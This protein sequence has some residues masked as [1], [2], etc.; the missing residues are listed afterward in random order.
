MKLN[1]HM[2]K[3]RLSLAGPNY[4]QNL[5]LGDDKLNVIL[6]L[7]KNLCIEQCTYRTSFNRGPN[8]N[9]VHLST[10][11]V[12]IMLKN[13]YTKQPDILKS[14]KNKPENAKYS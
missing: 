9:A 13:L 14:S 12:E 1:I 3:P 6:Q 8:T 11:Y 7:T 5:H 10:N 4:L 2:K